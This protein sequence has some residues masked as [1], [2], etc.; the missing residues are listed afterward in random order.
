ME[1]EDLKSLITNRHIEIVLSSTLAKFNTLID[2]DE[3]VDWQLIITPT[4]GRT[5]LVCNRLHSFTT[6]INSPI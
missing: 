2:R 6:L 4:E 3:L 5:V 1:M